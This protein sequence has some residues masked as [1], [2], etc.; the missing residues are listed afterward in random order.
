MALDP[1]HVGRKYGPFKYQL[2]L[3]KMREFAAVIAGG[4][5]GLGFGRA[6]PG[7]SP[8][9]YDEEAAKAGPYGQVI[10]FPTF[11]TTFAMTAFGAAVSDPEVGVNLLMLVHGEQD[12]EF[13][14]V[15]RAGDTMTTVGTITEIYEKAGKD[16]L[17]L[18]TESTNQHGKLVVRGTWTAV[19]RRG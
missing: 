2:G 4:L 18:V 8:L 16:F 12:F 5:P 7:L 19:I 6:P 9:L 13:F 14:D 3:E 11:A 10:A 1:K 15:M 17:V